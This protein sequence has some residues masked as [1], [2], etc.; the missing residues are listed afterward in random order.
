MISVEVG[1]ARV[2]IRADANWEDAE[3]PAVVLIHGAGMDHTAFLY[4]TR[5]LGAQRFAAMAVDLPGH[6][7]SGGDPLETIEAMGSWL[8]QLLDALPQSRFA[9]L[10]HSMGSLVALATGALD[11]GRVAA[12]VLIGTA[13]HMS[14]HPE[15]LESARAGD[16]HAIQLMIGWMRTGQHR[17]GGE[18]G[19]G[20]WIP[21]SIEQTMLRHL[22]RVLATDLNACDIYEPVAVAQGLAQPILVIQGDDDR[23]TPTKGARAL[24]ASMANATMIEIESAGHLALIEDPRAVNGHIGAFLATLDLGDS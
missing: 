2:A 23:M 6:G 14:V 22:D 20:L 17:Y 1:G 11:P 12:L 9:L 3:A 15:L 16:R 13:D 5:S 10:G 4:Q 7:R 19:A 18:A 8:C 24:T 21:G